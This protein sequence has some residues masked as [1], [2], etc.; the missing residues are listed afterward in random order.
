[1]PPLPEP[2]LV[3]PRHQPP[4]QLRG[5]LAVLPERA[6]LVGRTAAW[7]GGAWQ[8]WPDDPVEVNVAPSGSVRRREGMAL[9]ARSYPASDLVRTRWG[10]ATTPLRT[11][12]DLACC[13][14]LET[15]VPVLDAVLRRTGLTRD[16][17]LERLGTSPPGRG[18]RRAR[19][20]LAS[21]D[22][23]A[24]FPRESLLR[25]LVVTAGLPTPEVQWEVER[26]DGH[27]GGRRG[28]PPPG[29]VP[30]S[31]G[32]RARVLRRRDGRSARSSSTGACATSISVTWGGERD[33]ERRR[34]RLPVRRPGAGAPG[35]RSRS[36][37]PGPQPRWPG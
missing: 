37:R 31:A 17:V 35:T 16:D 6:V 3:G 21:T 2:G 11:A 4:A 28:V 5:L 15:A 25:L 1:M 23:R 22:P 13:H 24:E 14:D 33:S 27:P 20:A 32:G 29:G 26:L 7:A 9:S 30:G 10:C 36:G 18:G 8:P 19:S 12:V 34:C